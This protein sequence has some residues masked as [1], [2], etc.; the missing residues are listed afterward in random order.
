MPNF[1]KTSL[2]RLATCDYRLQILFEEV[3][4]HFDCTVI[5]GHRGQA[6]QEA[7]YAARKSRARFGQS[8]HNFEP[9][10]AVDVA[11]YPIDWNDLD[12][13][14]FFGGFVLGVAAAMGV[15]LRWGG[16]WNGNRK[17]SDNRFNDL[18]HFE[19]IGG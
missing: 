9:S 18:P 2:D 6:E 5:C 11:P 3:V 13:F 12:R 1:S 16:D 14:Q 19:L 8:P 10:R 7:A 4:K 17:L 15:P